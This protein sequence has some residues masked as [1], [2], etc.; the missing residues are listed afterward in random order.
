[1]LSSNGIKVML[2]DDHPVTRR[3]LQEVLEDSSGFV[4]VAL[5]GDGV[6]ASPRRRRPGPISSSWT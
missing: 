6:E 3:G 4:V 5:A 2:V 1:M